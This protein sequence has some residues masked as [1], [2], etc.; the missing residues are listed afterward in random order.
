MRR[1]LLTAAVA[2]A[3]AG[4][5]QASD[6]TAPTTPASWSGPYIGLH[7][8]YGRGENSWSD[9]TD[10]VNHTSFPGPDATYDIGGS[11]AGGQIGYN[12]QRGRVVLGVEADVSWS[13]IDGSGAG[14]I[15]PT[16]PGGCLQQTYC[17]SSFDALGTFTGRLGLT[18]EHSLFY[19]KGGVAW[20]RETQETGYDYDAD[21]SFNYWS[22][23]SNT[24]WGWTVGAGLEVAVAQNWSV[25]AEYN[26]IDLGKDDVE[27]VYAPP[28]T[29]G[30]RA[31]ADEYLHTFNVG[32][33]YRFGN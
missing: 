14:S 27:F 1:V 17:K 16:F 31:D 15:E 13:G 8:G 24:R 7:V 18:V 25:R 32:L 26:Y 12:W 30:A 11:L 29:F 10:P 4:L 9:F 2:V 6:M 5:A 19:A 22:D 21:P 33:N 3:S 20:A 28:Q 23:P